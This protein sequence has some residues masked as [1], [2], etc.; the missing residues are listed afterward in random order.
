M[1]ISLYYLKLFF[2]GQVINY[3]GTW[4]GREVHIRIDPKGH[5][6]AMRSI[7]N[8]IDDRKYEEAQTE[9]LAIERFYSDGAENDP[10]VIRTISFMEFMKD[11]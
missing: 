4:F 7:S 5:K 9:I 2:R 10:E 6:E 1:K 11:D 8:L 3:Y